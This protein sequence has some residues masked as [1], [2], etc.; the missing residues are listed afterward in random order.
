[1]LTNQKPP[2][3]K[4]KN[5]CNVKISKIKGV[6]MLKKLALIIVL[7]LLAMNLFFVSSSFANESVIETEEPITE[8]LITPVNLT[9]SEK[10]QLRQLGFSEEE[11]IS[12]SAE[13]FDSYKGLEGELTNKNEQ[14]YRLTY[15]LLTDKTVTEQIPM[16]TALQ[17]SGYTSSGDGGGGIIAKPYLPPVQVMTKPTQTTTWMKMTTTSTKL[18]GGKFLIKNSF[19]W[20]KSPQVA[21][22]DVLGITHSAN[23]VKIPGTD[24]F[25][26]KYT[27]GRGTHTLSAKST[28]T[29]SY[30]IAK[31]FNLKAIGTDRPPYN[32]NGYISIQVQK[33]NKYDTKSN[34]YGHYTHT[35]GGLTGATIGLTPG[36]MT[37]G[38]GATTSKMTDTMI[39]L[40]W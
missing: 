14:Y 25:A 2:I 30:G 20:L 21:F 31:R 26:Y 19:T 34:A 27:D 39:L 5:G 15:D 11:I 12:M 23:V 18:T 24:K 38:V 16:K 28:V 36:G 29:N 17:E 6:L 40:T 35:E 37:L 10:E 3:Y 8:E 4:I 7:M 13:E 9:S 1:M 22:V 33:S 32:H